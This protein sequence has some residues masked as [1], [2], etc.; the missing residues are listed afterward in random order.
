MHRVLLAL[1]LGLIVAG[2]PG[3]VRAQGDEG[4]TIRVAAS[5]EGEE[6]SRQS[7]LWVMDVDLKPL[8]VIWVDIK[9]P[10]TGE[11]EQELFY[12]ICY[13]A[14]NRPLEV[15]TARENEPVNLL[16]DE[17]GPPYF[18]PEFTLIGEDVDP[19]AVFLDEVIPEVQAAIN[20]KERRT[21][22]NSV[23]IVGPVPPAT[24]ESPSDENALFGVAIFRG[25]DPAIDFYTLYMSGFSNGYLTGQTPDGEPLLM[26]KTIVQRF[27]RPGDQFNPQSRDFRVQGDARWIYRPDAIA[28]TVPAAEA[29]EE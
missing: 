17:P 5:A 27:W 9:N 22:K 6:R 8:R 21:F 28:P 16:D 11:V 3:T 19:P 18:I 25:V 12:Y 10:Q 1:G 15:P 23:S 29:E 2:L 20:R 14:V 7:S 24:A 13:R 4:F 26:R